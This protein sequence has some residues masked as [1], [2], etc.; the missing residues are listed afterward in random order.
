MSEETKFIKNIEYYGDQRKISLII[1]KLKEYNI[2]PN[3]EEC[4]KTYCRN[5]LREKAWDWERD[6]RNGKHCICMR[7]SIIYPDATQINLNKNESFICREFLKPSEESFAYRGELNKEPG[8]CLLCTRLKTMLNVWNHIKNKKDSDFLLQNHYNTVGGPNG[9]SITECIWTPSPNEP[10]YGIVLPIVSY[11]PQSY[12]LSK[13]NVRSFIKGQWYEKT[14]KCIL[15]Q[16]SFP[17]EGIVEMNSKDNL[18]YQ[19]FQKESIDS[20][21]MDE[22]DDTSK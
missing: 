17:V 5:Y 12:I 2:D 14:V 1:N 11:N 13:T 8:L 6:C 10:W 3:I 7:L 15:E 18:N 20:L 19:T 21:I 9:Y 16:N 22:N 4:S